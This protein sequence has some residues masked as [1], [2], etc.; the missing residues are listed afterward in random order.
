MHPRS[1]SGQKKLISA[2]RSRLDE[3]HELGANAFKPTYSPMPSKP[4]SPPCISRAV[5]LPHARLW[6]KLRVLRLPSRGKRVDAIQKVFCKSKC[7]R[8]AKARQR[9][10]WLRAKDPRT[11]RDLRSKS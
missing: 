8:L 7:R 2:N 6:L 3:A 9:I 10:V 11:R 5:S 1:Q 4:L